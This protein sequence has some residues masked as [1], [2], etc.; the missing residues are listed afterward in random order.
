MR[1]VICLALAL[2]LVGCGSE[3][4][5]E[6]TT[7][8]VEPL[9]RLVV[10][11]VN[12]PLAYFADR[13]G[14]DLV[15]VVFPAPPGE[16]PAY[17]SP[18][19]ETIAA[20]QSADLILLNGAGY[21]RWAERA[22]LPESKLVDTTAAAGDRLLELAGTVTHSH[23]PEGEHEHHGWAFTTW[24][25]PTLASEQAR[26]VAAALQN[27]QPDAAEKI[28]ERLAGLEADLIA[29]DARFAAA[30]ETIGDKPL[31][32]SHPVYQYLIARYGLNGSE[33]HWEPDVEP[34]GKMWS[35]LG[36]LL[37]HHDSEWMI[38]EGEPLDATVAAL[39][40]RGIDSV[41]FSPCASTPADGDWMTVMAANAAALEHVA[42]SD[43]DDE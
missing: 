29:L 30:A 23:G 28:G 38:W 1:P 37:E 33:I 17:W 34:D 27:R 21:A 18:D 26:A 5:A 8:D 4:P 15:E 9:D 35:E 22:T 25:D 32:F 42:G 24:L 40:Q 6:T 13:L 14:G 19:A 10:F 2:T 3:Q 12:Y 20:Y 7:P 16:D 11:S 41:V 36:H 39:N 31:I 43:H